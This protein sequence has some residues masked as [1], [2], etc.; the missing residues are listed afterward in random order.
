MSKRNR[1]HITYSN[2]LRL[3]KDGCGSYKPTQRKAAESAKDKLAS[4]G[5]GDVFLHR[6][7]NGCI[8]EGITVP[9]AHD[10]RSSKG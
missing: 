7:D 2:D 1:A 3:W 10:P 6:K 5:G 8:R 4:V 9:P